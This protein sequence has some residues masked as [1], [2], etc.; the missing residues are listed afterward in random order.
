MIV[1]QYFYGNY[2]KT[3]QPRAVFIR[4]QRPENF[5]AFDGAALN[6]IDEIYDVFNIYKICKY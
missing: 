2:F 1:L 6:H 3:E 5:M 4:K